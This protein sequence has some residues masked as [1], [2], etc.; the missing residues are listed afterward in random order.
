M[1]SH[2][3]WVTCQ[4]KATDRYGRTVAVCANRDGDLGARLV[5][6]GMAIAYRRY[7]TAYVDHEEAAEAGRAGIWAGT[8]TPPEQWR[9]EHRR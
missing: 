2:R 5:A 6:T 9:R 7:S 1:L 4:A 3:P 8:F